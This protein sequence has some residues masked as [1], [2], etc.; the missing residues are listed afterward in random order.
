MPQ[1]PGIPVPYLALIRRR[2]GLTQEELAARMQPPG[3]VAAI[4]RAENGG[5]ARPDTIRRWAIALN[6]DPEDLTTPLEER[7][8]KRKRTRTGAPGLQAKHS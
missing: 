5:P 3:G 8:R 7:S 1:R 4:S 2:K 6:C